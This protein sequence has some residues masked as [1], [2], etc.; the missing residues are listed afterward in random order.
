VSFYSSASISGSILRTSLCKDISVLSNESCGMFALTN[1]ATIRACA[2][3][4]GFLIVSQVAR[5]ES[6]ALCN[7]KARGSG[8][9]IGTGQPGCQAMY[10]PHE[11][12]GT[13][14]LMSFGSSFEIV[15][16]INLKDSG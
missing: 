4:R 13:F 9:R 2:K 8:T 14:R 3:S 16:L 11:R 5:P 1:L 6:Q 12:S 15:L 7:A 10:L